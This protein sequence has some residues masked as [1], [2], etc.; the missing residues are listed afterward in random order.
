MIRK[1][2][3]KPLCVFL[4]DA[5]GDLDNPFGNWPL[6][7]QQMNAALKYMKYDVRFDYTEGSGTNPITTAA[8]S[9]KP[10]AGFGEIRT[11]GTAWR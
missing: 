4:E 8:F 1:T 11:V 5:S 3:R 6:A 10:C 7:N 9:L 2:E